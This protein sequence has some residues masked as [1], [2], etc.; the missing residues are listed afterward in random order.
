[1]RL[2]STGRA[3]DDVQ[4]SL[5]AKMTAAFG[6]VIFMALMSSLVAFYQLSEISQI[7]QNIK[8]KRMPV[9]LSAAQVNGAI[10]EAS[11]QFRNYMI[12]GDDTELAAKYDGLR[13][14][15]WEHLLNE[16]EKMKSLVTGED[17]NTLAQLE[18]HVRNGNIKIQMDAMPDLIGRGPAAR[19]RALER[20]KAGSGLA[21]KSK[22]DSAVLTKSV[23]D[24]LDKDNERLTS[25]QRT[26]RI[27][28][29][30]LL[31][32]TIGIVVLMG[33]IFSKHLTEFVKVL[34]ERM[35]L[36]ADGDL[37]GAALPVDSGDETAMVFGSM[38]TMQASLK[39]TITSVSESAERVASASEEISSSATEIAQ[40]SEI[41]KDQTA[42]VATA[43]QQ[44][45]AT[46]T[47]VN[48]ASAMA[49]E[50]ARSAGELARTGGKIVADTVEMIRGV[51]DSTR[52]TAGKIEKLG[53]SGD[54]I[55]VIIGVIDDIA[56][57]TNLLALNAAIEAARA[58]EQG[59]GFAVVADE[60][61]K[62]AERTTKATKEVS[63]KILTIQDETKTAVEAM[64]AGNSK[65]EAGVSAANQ[66]SDAL[67]KII[68][69]AMGMQEMVTHIATAAVEQNSA[70]SDVNQSMDEIAK[71]V[72]ASSVSAR[73]SAKACQDLSSLGMDLQQIV[74]RFKTGGEKE[75]Y[76]AAYR[77]ASQE[78]AQLQ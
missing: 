36:I 3:E 43:M 27:T 12:Y 2:D 29:V 65:V 53:R 61:R 18:D 58:G 68:A 24:A 34:V 8:T 64:K 57:Q 25:L 62:L 49:S 56:D 48:Q 76:R 60:V 1:M 45:A 59:R 46:V 13:R 14:A 19:Q 63:E 38:N 47:Q 73:E 11:F 7:Q 77:P 37:R 51:A 39:R 23:L 42:Q 74:N 21:A 30:V 16:I 20:M 32:A 78:F 71:M 5:K 35:T 15:A 66:A 72:Q 70:A 22:A 50:N 6:A 44:M 52:E 33:V 28:G 31:F 9:A 67:Q 4:L 40:S 41:Q 75:I 55:G 17:Q 26:A 69:S 54:Q 10:S